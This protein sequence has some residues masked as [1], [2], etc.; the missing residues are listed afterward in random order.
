MLNRLGVFGRPFIYAVRLWDRFHDAPVTLHI[1]HWKAGSQWLHRILGACCP[2]RLVPPVE[3][4]QHLMHRP[5]RHGLVYPTV[6]ATREQLQSVPFPCPV[7]RFIVI[8]DP[9]DTLVS[10]YFS[11]KKSHVPMAEL[12]V[13]ERRRSA[14]QSLNVEEGLQ[15]LI[16]ESL[17][18]ARIIRSWLG[19]DDPLIR[20]EDLLEDDEAILDRVL[21]GHC[22]LPV[23]RRRLRRAVRENRFEQR[24]GGRRRGQEDTGAHERKGIAGDWRNHFTPRVKETF[25]QCYGDLLIAAGYERDN[26]W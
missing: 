23:T 13:I 12:P 19:G 22:R 26:N 9:R 2:S 20:Y 21:R 14:L 24:T 11:M 5:M 15:F 17:A 1:T 7:K 6:Y 4:F 10:L 25:L 3:G 8:R 16:P 18:I